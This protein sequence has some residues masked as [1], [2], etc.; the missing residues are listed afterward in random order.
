MKKMRLENVQ[1]KDDLWVTAMDKNLRFLL[2]MQV[3]LSVITFQR[4][5]WRSVCFAE[6]F[7]KIRIMR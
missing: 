2:D 3:M 6:N 1:M 4:L 7:L 5:L